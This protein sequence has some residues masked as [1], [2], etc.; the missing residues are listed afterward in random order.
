MSEAGEEECK[1]N[2]W[3]LRWIG[4]NECEGY[5]KGK[6][7]RKN[8]YYCRKENLISF[9]KWRENIHGLLG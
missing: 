7:G 5:F 4:N 1:W 6:V 3:Q 8:Q 2:W 9:V